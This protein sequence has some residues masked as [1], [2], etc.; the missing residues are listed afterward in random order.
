MSGP[1]VVS[2]AD[3][4]VAPGGSADDTAALLAWS[5]AVAAAVAAGR[6]CVAYVPPGVYIT[7]QTLNG[8]L[9]TGVVLQ[10]A[11]VA[12]SVIRLKNGA[13]V[14][15]M[16]TVGFAANTGT[17][18]PG[19][20]QFAIQ[21]ITLDGNGPNNAAVGSWTVQIYGYGYTVR[22][23][24]FLNGAQGNVYSEWGNDGA[25]ASN[26]N[27]GIEA[28]WDC[29]RIGQAVGLA[30]PQ[31]CYG[32]WV[33]GPP[34]SMF[35]NG[36][37]WT[38]S[39]EHASQ[40]PSYGLLDDSG[41][42]ANQYSNIHV[43]GRHHFAIASTASGQF[44]GCQSEGASVANVA[45]C[46]YDCTW[47]GGTVYGTNGN[48]GT[49]PNEVGFMLGTPKGTLAATQDM[50]AGSP[51]GCAIQGVNLHAFTSPGAAFAGSNNNAGGNIINATVRAYSDSVYRGPLHVDDDI[52]IINAYGRGHV[53]K[54]PAYGTLIPHP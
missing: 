38:F 33:K 44:V 27:I 14:P 5:Q 23:A 52:R 16:Q 39:A 53:M 22:N 24:N 17:K 18:N 4:G 28:K 8:L 32:L 40:G 31:P 45:F 15:L 6:G 49:Q 2:L 26:F 1:V 34:N 12:S 25:V 30:S 48:G 41:S 9:D 43:Y 47:T 51:Q 13:G 46:S 3:Y 35:S 21:D 36:T 19:P 20:H 29:F 10:G 54:S 7:A 37:I 50:I 11:G 42:S